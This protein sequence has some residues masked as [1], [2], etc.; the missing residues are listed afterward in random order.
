[1]YSDMYT[2]HMVGKQIST[3]E[4]PKRHPVVSEYELRRKNSTEGI[5]TTAGGAESG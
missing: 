3:K 4:D 2:V 1:M 5:R